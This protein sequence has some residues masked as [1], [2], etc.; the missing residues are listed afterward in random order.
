MRKGGGKPKGPLR[1]IEVR[2]T[3]NSEIRHPSVRV[4]I[5]PA[6][7]VGKDEILGV[8]PIATALQ[9]ANDMKVDLILVSESGDI[10]VCKLV[11][12]TKWRYMQEKKAKNLKKN[13]K[14]T[15]VKEIKMSYK[16]DVGDLKVRQ[17]NCLKFLRSGNRVKL[18]IQFK[19][20]EQSHMD[21]GFELLDRFMTAPDLEE[22]GAME[23]KP[24][25]EGRGISVMVAVR[26]ERLKRVREEEKALSRKKK[27]EDKAKAQ[28]AEEEGGN[29]GEEEE[30]GT[31]T[32]NLEE[33]GD[34]E[35]IDVAKETGGEKDQLLNELF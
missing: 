1:T 19:G 18:N 30:A 25:K 11:E 3:M 16:I 24:K 7:G 28:A 21:L 10:P 26:Q 4:S 34:D 8:L 14:S 6:T 27:K 13:S 17:K 22:W 33:E 23:G 15:E 32:I 35:E 29:A 9:K 2:P 5:P 20:R 12:Y 31:P